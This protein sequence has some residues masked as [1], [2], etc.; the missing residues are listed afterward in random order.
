MARRKCPIAPCGP[1]AEECDYDSN[2]TRTL[3]ELGGDYNGLVETIEEELCSVEGLEGVQAEARKGRPGGARFCWKPAMGDDTAGAAKTTSVSMAWRKTAKWLGDVQH[4]K[5]TKNA[6]S[7]RWKV[8]FNRHPKP[9]PAQANHE[10]S[11]SFKVFEDWRGCIQRGQVHSRPWLEM[12]KH[13]ATKQAEKEEAA[14]QLASINSYK[15]WIESGPAKGLRR[16]HQFS[17]NATGWTETALDKDNGNEVGDHDDLDGLSEEQ[18]E[19]IKTK[20]GDASS[21]ANAQCEANDQAAA[22]KEVWGGELADRNNPTW[23]GDLGTIPP[24]IIVQAL[25]AAANTFRRETG[26]GWDRL[27]PRV[28]NRLSHGTLLWVCAVLHNAERKRWP[29][30]AELVLIPLLPNAEGGFRA[31]LFFYH[32][33]CG[34]G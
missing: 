30:A 34:F 20:V 5:C 8:R 24:M 33:S 11:M 21:P 4:T 28:L 2:D 12:L 31:I 22:W 18:I 26:L 7:A 6:E 15:L 14:A 13:V 3:E 16:Q 29:A 10:Q 23:P 19:A 9:D 1:E 17:R 25:L 27:H 32:F